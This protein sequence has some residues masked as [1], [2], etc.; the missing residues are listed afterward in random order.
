MKPGPICALL[1]LLIVPAT[2]F[3]ADVRPAKP[4]MKLNI[5]PYELNSQVFDFPSGLRIVMQSDRSH[6]VVTVFS[7]VN[8]GTKDDPEGKEETAHFV[9]HTWF[10]SK[11]GSLPPIMDLIQDI[12]TRFNATTHNDWTDFRTVASSEYLPLMLRLESLRLTEPYAGVTEE[13]IDVERE[14]IR[15]E[16]RRRNEQGIAQLFDYIYESV[17][18]EDHGYHDHSTHASIDN[19]KLADLQKFMD[20]YYKPEN[21]TIFVVGDFDPDEAGSL[22]FANVAPKLLHPDLSDT[23]YFQAPKPG[24]EHPDQNNPDDWLTGAYEPGG[25]P[26]HREMFRFAPRTEPRIT[27][28]RPPVPPVGTTEV[29]TKQAPVDYKMVTIGWSLPGGYR[30]DHWNLIV[31]GNTAGQYIASAFREEIDAKRIGDIG[32]FSQTEILNTTVMCYAELK[33][34]KLDP[35]DVRDKMLDQLAEIWNPDN[36][37]GGTLG[38]NIS[39]TLQTRAKM[40]ILAN[41]LLNL[42]VFAQEF[43]GRAEDTVPHLHYTLTERP[44]SEG[45]NQVMSIDPKSISDL[46][47]AY[48]KR[49]R[50]A[51][52][53]L[54]PLPEDEID[55]GSENSTYR[56]ANATDQVLRTGDDLKTLTDDQIAASYL[57]PDMKAM[58]DFQLPNGLRVVVLPHGDMPV[59]Q[60][61]LVVMRDVSTEPRGMVSG[62][63]DPNNNPSLGFAPTFTRS[64]GH[65]PLPIA[66]EVNWYLWAGIPGAPPEIAPPPF[67]NPLAVNDVWGNALRMT[68]KAPSGNLDGALWVLREELDTASP[69]IDDKTGWMKD[70]RDTLK[71]DW[72]SRDWHLAQARNQYLFPNAPWHQNLTWEDLEKVDTWGNAEI[73]GYL[74]TVL[75]PANATLLIVG[76]I[77]VESAKKLALTYFG[78][79]GPRPGAGAAPKEPSPPAMPTEPSKILIYDDA[80]RTQ[81]DLYTQ[82]RLNVTD[83]TQEYAV[84]VLSSLLRNQT[85]STMRVKE[86][87]AYSPG[88]GASIGSDGASTLTFY[89]DGVVNSGIGRMYTFFGEAIR[90]IEAGE[91]NPEEV[92]LH[93]LRQARSEGVSAQSI[94][95]VTDNMSEIIRNG[96][97]WDVLTKRGELI[98]S[99][100]PD[101]M[102]PLLDGCA[103]HS[104]TTLVG[105]KDVIT[106]Q[107]DELGLTY[108]V[109]E[110]KANG[111]ELLWKYDPKAAKKREK[112]RSKAEKKK[113]KEAAKKEKKG[114]PTDAAE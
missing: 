23:D 13:E 74:G 64:V 79:W 69:Y 106:P 57:V 101:D 47:Y 92:T 100:S 21:T 67:A 29:R 3:A 18:P 71:A 16:W 94:G 97:N 114:T 75:Q 61:S 8:H 36:T 38:A 37:T 15:N 34:D 56:G 35:L 77:E 17:Y 44:Q 110:W 26:A 80:K 30:S 6:P 78:G 68:I 7:M 25:D 84:G 60:A 19:I 10:R 109:V 76:N 49:D 72:G 93:K 14:V 59:V 107:L 22:I 32:C 86:G 2:S 41:L 103:E 55:I 108:S 105:P 91:V 4:E 54:E 31:V 51:T 81:T 20:D 113:N 50:A 104:I 53:I 9:E 62:V 88:A 46:A 58:T 70:Q 5:P 82:C 95:Q 102:K 85:F 96:Q 52:V 90:A 39:N 63:I 66:G 24:I 48:L 73:N 112:D 89:S 99:V 1:S 42:D 43:G 28:E 40:E 83:R 11:H 33:D 65:D 87:L 98:A 111:D 27:E 12:G 45:M